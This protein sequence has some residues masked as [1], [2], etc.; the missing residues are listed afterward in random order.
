LVLLN[1]WVRTQSGIAK[2]HLKHYYL[3]RLADREFWR[4]VARGEFP[5][6]AAAR[7]FAGTFIA[8]FG[9]PFGAG[10]ASVEGLSDRHADAVAGGG[11]APLPQ[12]MAE[13]FGRFKGKVLL[14][15]S[16]KDLTAQEF[17]EAVRNSSRWETLLAAPR[18]ARRTLPEADHTFSRREWRD[19]VANWTADW[20]RSW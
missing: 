12:R 15:L 14:I 6:V 16:G 1:P 13:D 9:A 3:S 19:Q 7:S 18:V 2:T 11:N 20:V 17:G 10:R 8:A 4:K 5:V